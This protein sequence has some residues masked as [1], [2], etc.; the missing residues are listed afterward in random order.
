MK[1]MVNERESAI[2][3]VAAYSGANHPPIPIES[4][5]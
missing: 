4:I 5:H 3:I 2:V 1:R